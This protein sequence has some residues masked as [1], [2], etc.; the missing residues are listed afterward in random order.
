M[1]FSA[2]TGA[3]GYQKDSVRLPIPLIPNAAQNSAEGFVYKY[4]P[5]GQ[6]LWGARISSPGTSQTGGPFVQGTATDSTGAVYAVGRGF[7]NASL[8]RFIAYQTLFYNADGSFGGSVSLPP[9]HIPTGPFCVKYSAT[10]TFQWAVTVTSPATHGNRGGYAYAVAVDSSD[11]VYFTGSVGGAASPGGVITAYNADGTAFGTTYPNRGTTNDAF[12][13]KYN[14]SGVAQWL[15]RVASTEED[16]GRG[17]AIDSTGVYMVGDS[18]S[19]STAIFTAFN[20][21]GTAFGTTV[22]RAGS[23]DMFIVKYTLTGTV[24]WVAGIRSTSDDNAYAAALDSEGNLVLAVATRGTASTAYNSD[25]TAFGTTIATEGLSDPFVVKYSSTG[26]VQWLA[27]M[28]GTGTDV[29]WGLTT[30]SG[31]NVYISGQH[32]TGAFTIFNSDGTAFGRSFPAQTGAPAFLVKYNSSGFVQWVAQLSRDSGTTSAVAFAAVSDTSD[33]IH[34]AVR[35]QNALIPRNSDGTSFAAIS[36]TT[37]PATCLVTYNSSGTVLRTRVLN[38]GSSPLSVCRDSANNIFVGGSFLVEPLVDNTGPS[39]TV[40]FTIPDRGNGDAVVVKYR[41]NGSPWWAARIAGLQTDHA[42]GVATDSSGNIYVTGV[43]GGTLGAGAGRAFNAD[44][45]GFGTGD[46]IPFSR[47][48]LVKYNQFGFVQWDVSFTAARSSTSGFSPNGAG[49]KVAVDSTGSAYVCGIGVPVSNVLSA[50]NPNGSSTRITQSTSG[51]NPAMLVKYD[52]NGIPQWIARI[53]TTNSHAFY[54]VAVD[55]SDNVIAVGYNSTNGVVFNAN[56]TSFATIAAGAVVVKYNSSGVVQW[57]ARMLN[58]NE[59]QAVTCDVS[60]NVYVAGHGGTTTVGVTIYNANGT[61]FTTL[62]VASGNN[63]GFVVKYNSVGVVQWVARI[64]S[65]DQDVPRSLATDLDGNLYLGGVSGFSTSSPTTPVLFF[66]ADGTRSTV[67]TG[68]A[69]TSAV[70]WLVKYSPSGRV[71]WN[72]WSEGVS[73]SPDEINGV[74]VDRRGEVHVSAEVYG[75]G[76]FVNL[77]YTSASTLS[78]NIPASTGLSA[79]KFTPQGL[80]R[81]WQRIGVQARGVAT[82][83][84]CNLIVVGR[85]ASGSTTFYAKA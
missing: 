81:W 1:P 20:A 37:T 71:Q 83:P 31:N 24:S 74:A 75:A 48:F 7:I 80:L 36:P 38:F 64:V 17:L 33:N 44:G 42:F 55:S 62:P 73:N 67:G 50:N 68:T 10:G 46:S 54:D 8:S 66:N 78:V 16:V 47:P 22:P 5:D 4:G 85:G 60:G 21:D 45:T 43:I 14:A 59:A 49:L 70:A 15:T 35:G 34:L 13:V 6:A 39:T 56:G 76:Y 26:T 58:A 32:S 9:N 82:D 28:G 29:G 52:T 57:V 53:A 19:S 30:D 77:A 18:Q 65:G 27:K 72:A 11:N 3:L 2:M 12:L 84:D 40:A 79:A 69:K 63:D 51:T 61:T 41:A 23:D 25:G